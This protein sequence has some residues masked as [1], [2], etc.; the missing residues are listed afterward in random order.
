MRELPESPLY[1]LFHSWDFATG[2]RFLAD[3][4]VNVAIYVPVGMFGFLAF[5]RF[6]YAGPIL[7]G[8]V[9]S[10]CIEMTQLYTPNRQCS[11][12]DLVTN[13][14][15]S[16][17]GVLVG[18]LFER[19]AGSVRVDVFGGRD[20]AALALLFC[21]VAAMLFPLFPD[22][23]L[24]D[25]GHK[26]RIFAHGPWMSPVP[27]VSAAASW[28]A[29][30][31]LLRSGVLRWGTGLAVSLFLV[32]AQLFILTRQ[33]LPVQM[34]GAVAGVALFA[35][36]RRLGPSIAAWG[37][38]AVLL[39]RGLVPFHLS[40]QAQTFDWIP[41][42]GFLNTDWQYAIQLFLEKLFYYGTAIWLLRQAGFRW[43]I[44]TA[45]VCGVLATIEIVQ[46]HLPGRTAEIT[47]PLLALLAGFG[48]RRLAIMRIHDQSP[49][50][51][52]SGES[53]KESRGA[54]PGFGA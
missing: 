18:I 50:R 22:T 46:I 17:L 31:L 10:G 29:A 14:G 2:R 27:L 20:R 43:L 9:L 4:I 42:E 21:W 25:W 3:I 45:W 7:A 54:V 23:S 11:T 6:R 36:A 32:P 38:V 49:I 16:I 48:L 40:A 39:I 15:G 28:F 5:R 34:V 41:F 47:D 52:D 35:F 13:I 19:T 26:F 8:T 53:G 51:P 1:L 33:P 24:P 37:F 12:V 44:A 30:G